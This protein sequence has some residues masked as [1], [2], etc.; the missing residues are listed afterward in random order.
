MAG[1]E[2]SEAKRRWW[3]VRFSLR[4]LVFFVLLVGS[5]GGLWWRWEAWE[6]TA[7]VL[8][9]AEPK[10][11]FPKIEFSPDGQHAAI[12]YRG[13][14]FPF[15]NEKR[16]ENVFHIWNINRRE[17]VFSGTGGFNDLMTSS[18][19]LL[20]S[21]DGENV[22]LIAHDGIAHWE[23]IWNLRQRAPVGGLLEE[24][25]FSQ[26]YSPN[27]RWLAVKEYGF[28]RGFLLNLQTGERKVPTEAIVGKA[29]F[30][31]N[32]K[33][34]C[35][36]GDHGRI[37]IRDL[38]TWSIQREFSIPASLPNDVG[39]LELSPNSK[40]LAVSGWSSPT[41]SVFDA[42]TGSV[43]YRVKGRV[44]KYCQPSGRDVLPSIPG[45]PFSADGR[46][47]MTVHAD[48]RLTIWHVDDGELAATIAPVV[49]EG[50][51]MVR[52]APDAERILVRG[53]NVL[54]VWSTTGRSILRIESERTISI[55]SKRGLDIDKRGD[56]SP[57]CSR[58]ISISAKG[59]VLVWDARD[60]TLI[61]EFGRR[62]SNVRKLSFTLGGDILTAH[63]DLRVRRW[64]PR[65]PEYWWGVAWLPEFW[66]TVVFASGLGWSVWRDR[67]QLAE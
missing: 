45:S 21:P 65:R 6:I 56:F 31:L 22:H 15:H 36:L 3:R 8:I 5:A 58:A 64:Q 9:D 62:G 40:Y 1:D 7:D 51:L 60:G 67:R 44:V 19:D 57:D 16:T 38:D 35:V 2:R 41:T 14:C 49:D 53:W 10:R 13:N 24:T 29:S 61:T 30:S 12:L 20:F 43:L 47:L 54:A 37:E 48:Q 42:A 32:G 33:T 46:F 25:F 26:Q 63:E 39:R 11:E 34:V 59:G 27:G 18:N 4:T 23:K 17:H 50:M 55:S 52:F 28:H 66:M